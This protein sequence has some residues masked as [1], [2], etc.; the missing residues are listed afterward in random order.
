MKLLRFVC[1]STHYTQLLGYSIPLIMY[2][3][4]LPFVVVLGTRYSC[5][6]SCRIILIQISRHSKQASSIRMPTDGD[7]AAAFKV[8]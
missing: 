1:H 7:G 8:L 3:S 5:C 2:S 6:I 4:D